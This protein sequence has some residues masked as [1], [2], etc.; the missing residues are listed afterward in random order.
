M[1]TRRVGW[2]RRVCRMFSSASTIVA[3]ARPSGLGSFP[4]ELPDDPV[5]SRV[6]ARSEPIDDRRRELRGLDLGR[7]LH[8]PGEVVGDDLLGDRRLERPD[9]VVGGALPAQVL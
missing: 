6:P 9:D 3:L 8:E 2:W 4:P 5:G 1:A 7:A